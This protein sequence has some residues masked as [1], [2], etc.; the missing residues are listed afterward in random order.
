MSVAALIFIWTQTVYSTYPPGTTSNLARAVNLRGRHP[1]I[2]SSSMANLVGLASCSSITSSELRGMPV[3]EL[4]SRSRESVTKFSDANHVAQFAGYL[5]YHEGVGDLVIPG[6]T[7]MSRCCLVT[8]YVNI[9]LT[10][11]NFGPGTKTVAALPLTMEPICTR[12]IDDT[13]GGWR[14][15]SRLPQQAWEALEQQLNAYV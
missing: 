10:A 3:A 4:A 5:A 1:D 13:Q 12:I 2:P 9:G 7:A 14:I 8:S 6:D 15:F 11:P